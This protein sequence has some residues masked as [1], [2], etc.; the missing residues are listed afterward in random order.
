MQLIPVIDLLDGL[1]VHAKCGK[2]DQYQPLNSILCHGSNPID[3]IQALL[4]LHS[5]KCV[6]LADLNALTAR[7][8]NWPLIQKLINQFSTVDF[9]I[10]QGLTRGVG[11]DS[12]AFTRV[13][14]SESV[15]QNFLDGIQQT[16]YKQFILSM[17][18]TERGFLGPQTLLTRDAEWPE[19][20]IVMS[21]ALVGSVAGPDWFRLNQFLERHPKRLIFSAGGTRSYSDLIRLKEMGVSGVLLASAL[22][23][24][25]L[26]S[27]EISSFD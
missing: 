10:D 1:A 27:A 22:H 7:G 25:S 3:I 12:S 15:G 5:F 6:Y 20:I 2:R 13:I 23:S 17:D 24:G 8:D 21:L 11:T 9:W 19:R 14:G 16:Q 18:F 4:C 26:N